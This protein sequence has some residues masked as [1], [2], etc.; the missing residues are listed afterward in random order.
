MKWAR[1]VSASLLLG[2]GISAGSF[3]WGSSRSG[4]LTVLSERS[5]M[6]VYGD[7]ACDCAANANCNQ[8]FWN[9]NQCAWCDV[10]GTY[11]TCCSDE[12]SDGQTCLYNGAFACG[13]GTAQGFKKDRVGD[14][15][16]CS[17]CQTGGGVATADG[18]CGHINSAG[19]TSGGC[20]FDLT[21]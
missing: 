12:G 4:H 14:V 15:A 7:A 21:K 6:A 16:T 19:G 17:T 10:G 5:A 18:S 9:G 13:N 2:L 1:V 11:R 3:A 8:K 20:S